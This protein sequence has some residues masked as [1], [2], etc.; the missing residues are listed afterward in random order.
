MKT[1]FCR[2]QRARHDINNFM[3]H[4]T[5]CGGWWGY[6]DGDKKILM[7]LS[8][9]RI[10]SDGGG[11]EFYVVIMMPQSQLCGSGCVWQRACL[12]RSNGDCECGDH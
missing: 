6:Q 1:H 2:L 4:G 8:S 9:L 5:V 3:H 11:V 12:N 7:A 10:P